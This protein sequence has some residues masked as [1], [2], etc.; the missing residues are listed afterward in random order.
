MPDA[1]LPASLSTATTYLLRSSSLLLHLSLHILP[2]WP[3]PPSERPIELFPEAALALSNIAF[4]E[5]QF[6]ATLRT[7]LV[8]PET[9]KKL[10]AK[11]FLKASELYAAAYAALQQLPVDALREVDRN[12]ELFIGGSAEFAR[13]YAESVLGLERFESGNVGD[14]IAL[15]RFF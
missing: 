13:C 9:S 15:V 4:A 2:A 6:C 8:R 11:L 5:A 14:A 3:D 10:L 12:F 7:M 1:T